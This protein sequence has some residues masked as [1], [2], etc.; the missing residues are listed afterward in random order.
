MADIILGLFA[1]TF[2]GINAYGGYNLQEIGDNFRSVIILKN[3]IGAAFKE[4]PLYFNGGVNYYTELPPND[5]ITTQERD[6]IKKGL[7]YQSFKKLN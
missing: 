3:R 1:P 4:I 7:Y 5:K 6:L 2:Y